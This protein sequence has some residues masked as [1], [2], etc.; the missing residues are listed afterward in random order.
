MAST[1]MEANHKSRTFAELSRFI[2]RSPHWRNLSI[3]IIAILLV[4]Y[5][6]LRDF[7]LVTVGIGGS[8][9]AVLLFDWIFVK[10]ARFEFPFRR[11][12][13]LN[14]LSLVIW[15]IFFWIIYFIHFTSVE[16]LIM[17]AIS[18]ISLVRVI[19][20]Y[21]YYSENS[22]KTIFPSLN[23]TYA[24]IISLFLVF[25]DVFTVIPFLLASLVYVIAGAIFVKSSTKKFI[26]EFGESPT[27][28]IKFFLNYKSG[29][30]SD[31]IGQKFF[32]KIYRHTRKI[33]VKVMEIAT[34]S[35]K[36]KTLLVFPYI[37]PGP[38]GRIGSSD[39][40]LRLQTR[41]KDLDTDLMVFHTT[42]TNSDNCRGDPDMDV[43]A[44]GIRKSI[45]KMS[46]VDTMSKFK[47]ITVGKYV[48]GMQKIGDFAYGA[49]IPEKTP[50][51]DVSM[52]EGLKVMDSI[53][54]KSLKDFALIDAQ[55][56]FTDGVRELDDCSGFASAFEREFARMQSRYPARAGYSRVS[57]SIEGLAT[58]GIQALVFNAGDSYQAIVLTDSNNITSEVISMAREKTVDIV[59]GL[60]IYTTDNHVVNAGSLDMNPLGSRCDVGGLTDQIKVVV[61]SA[62]K[63][64]EDVRIGMATDV[65]K[66]KMG[67]ENSFQNLI[68]LVFSSL[69]TAKYILMVAIPSAIVISFVIFRALLII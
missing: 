60:E 45:E 27:E 62:K 50:F 12:M 10:V 55:N 40:P 57:P 22:S 38:F 49:L 1:L 20:L 36:R 46:Y 7:L 51:D 24:A 44:E 4:D 37:H 48:I 67:D 16:Y 47:K 63:D 11:I 64:I 13:F 56:H 19:I 15:S 41:L 26:E 5:F 69:K 8:F 54:G 52:S 68:E 6:I 3:P 43:I 53:I 23:Y 14:F 2:Y 34:S 59:D 28:M 31:R 32:E 35:G 33:P 9:L 42:T 30:N 66:V 65:V 17:I 29:E 39:L 58:M 61:E 18:S 25:R 21:G